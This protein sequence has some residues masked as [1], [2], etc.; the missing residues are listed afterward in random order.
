MVTAIPQQLNYKLV[1]NGI[2]KV[3]AIVDDDLET[4]ND[5]RYDLEELGYQANIITGFH[6]NVRILAQQIHESAYAAICDHKLR[7]GGLADFYGSELVAC[8]YDLKT[9]SI[10]ISQY[11]D[12]KHSTIGAYRRKIPIFLTRDEANS[13]SLKDGI[14]YCVSELGGKISRERKPHRTLVRVE[15]VGKE[16]GEDV[17]EAFVV[18][19]RPRQAVRFPVSLIPEEMRETLGKGSRLV[20]YV[21]IGATKSEDLFFEKFELAPQLNANDGLA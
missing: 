12:D 7:D 9:P 21:N 1:G 14:E 15:R 6:E 11:P 2:S 3:V 4:A 19:W 5:T 8:L 20:A 17:V 16:F 13:M 18:G 10:L